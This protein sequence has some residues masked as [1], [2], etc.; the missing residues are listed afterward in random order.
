MVLIRVE[1]VAILSIHIQFSLIITYYCL[2]TYNNESMIALSNNLN[3]DP[4][5]D[6]DIIDIDQY[7]SETVLIDKGY[8]TFCN[9]SNT[10]TVGKCNSKQHSC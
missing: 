9:C 2:P 10:I 4:I 6:I 8:E 7:N 3:A 5:M 1:S